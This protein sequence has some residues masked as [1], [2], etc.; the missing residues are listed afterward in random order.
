MTKESSLLEH[1]SVSLQCHTYCCICMCSWNL[2]L[3]TVVCSVLCVEFCTALRVL[4][5]H[6]ISVVRPVKKISASDIIL[7]GF[8]NSSHVVLTLKCVFI[9]IMVYFLNLFETKYE[10]QSTEVVET[11]HYI[12]YFFFLWC[13]GPTRVMASSF[14]RF[15]DHIQRCVTVGRT[16]LDEWSARHR[17][18]Y[19]TTHDTRHRQTSMAPA[20]FEPTIPASERP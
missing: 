20:G 17:D 19:L 1:S 2:L 3:C 16:P 8:W 18:L 10:T 7:V 15:L 11:V 9:L 12:K 14:L 5:V 4:Q 13:C 6:S